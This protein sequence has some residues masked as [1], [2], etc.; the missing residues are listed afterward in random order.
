MLVD[1]G[2]NDVGK[3]RGGR[4][5]APQSVAHAVCLLQCRGLCAFECTYSTRRWIGL[6]PELQT[7][8]LILLS[9]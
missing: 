4:R 6:K 9:H 8:L 7:L 2:R 5:G 1:L 3:V